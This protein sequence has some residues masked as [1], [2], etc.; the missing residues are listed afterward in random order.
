MSVL[1]Q[2]SET[3]YLDSYDLTSD[4]DMTA[5]GIRTGGQVNK[6]LF[7]SGFS[8]FGRS[9]ASLMLGD[10]RVQRTDIAHK[11]QSGITSTRHYSNT[12]RA[13]VPQVD[14]AVGMRYDRGWF[15]VSAGYEISY[16]FAMYQHL[17]VVGHDDVDDMTVPIRADRGDLSFDGWFL[18]SGVK[19]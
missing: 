11:Q 1:Y 2:N 18:E 6:T 4:V 3:T 17:D 7:D 8:L 14:L 9:A 19:F 12:Y 10:F 16:W 13:V 15:Y 5:W